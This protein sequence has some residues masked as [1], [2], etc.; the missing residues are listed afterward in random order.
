MV[1]ANSYAGNAEV[2][3]GAN[4]VKR[5]DAAAAA[6]GATTF[7]YDLKLSLTPVHW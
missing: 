3:A 6:N 5:A 2:G 4:A 7:N 1:G